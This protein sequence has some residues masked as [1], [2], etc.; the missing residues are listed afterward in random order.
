M[1]TFFLIR[2]FNQSQELQTNRQEKPIICHIPHIGFLSVLDTVR[3]YF[4]TRKLVDK[5]EIDMHDAFWSSSK[6]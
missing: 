3:R 1:L 2:N 6:F 5:I 4:D